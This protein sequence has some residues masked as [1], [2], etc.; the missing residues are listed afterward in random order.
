[1]RALAFNQSFPLKW[2]QA[3]FQIFTICA[4]RAGLRTR[5]PKGVESSNLSLR[6]PA[7]IPA[8]AGIFHSI[9]RT[10]WTSPFNPDYIFGMNLQTEEVLNDATHG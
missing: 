6:P 1:M 4:G 7:K 10:R 3:E 8:Y 5:L 9:R 2:V